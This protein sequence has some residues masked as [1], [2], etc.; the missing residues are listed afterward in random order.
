L[1]TVDGFSL[2]GGAPGSSPELKANFAVT[3]YVTPSTQG[4]TLGA[5][6]GGPAVSPAQPGT[7]PASVSP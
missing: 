3:S 1:L 6:P 5:T 7:T 4:L 2:L